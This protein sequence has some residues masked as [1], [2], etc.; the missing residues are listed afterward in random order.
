MCPFPCSLEG[1][2]P[3]QEKGLSDLNKSE[4]E[5]LLKQGAYAMVTECEYV[6]RFEVLR[7]GFLFLWVSFWFFFCGNRTLAFSILVLPL[8][9]GLQCAHI[10]GEC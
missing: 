3:R 1:D 7:F 4:I 9:T 2:E 5:R 6:H 8:S 10:S